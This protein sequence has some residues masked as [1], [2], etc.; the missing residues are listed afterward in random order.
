MKKHSFSF[1]CL[2]L[3]LIIIFLNVRERQEMLCSECKR[4]KWTEIERK[5]D[6]E[7]TLGKKVGSK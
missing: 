1:I 6:N 3:Y 7:K 2:H 4:Q 5:L